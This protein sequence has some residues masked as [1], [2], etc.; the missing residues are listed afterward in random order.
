MVRADGGAPFGWARLRDGHETGILYEKTVPG[1]I[2][3]YGQHTGSLDV[4]GGGPADRRHMPVH[5]W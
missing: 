1:S 2:G 4:G 5:L 3:K